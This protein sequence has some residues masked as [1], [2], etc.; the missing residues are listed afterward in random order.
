MNDSLAVCSVERVGDFDRQRE[1]Q[2][3]LH[4]LAVD[5]VLQRL[6]REALHHDEEVAI[7]LA[8]LVDS[9]DI[10]VIQ[11]RCG[12]G[13]AAEALKSLGVVG[14]IVGKKFEGDE[15]AERGVL[16]LVDD[17]H[18]TAAE[19]LNDAVMGDS[20]ADHERSGSAQLAAK[21]R[22]RERSNLRGN[23]RESQF[24]G[25]FACLAVF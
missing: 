25:S 8:D 22:N 23:W 14:R 21:G 3:Q 11:S 19:K 10:G 2:V 17:T 13:L 4:R 7:M 1:K 18:P 15:A 20:L 12:A 6:A 9:A 16:G 24:R 5:Q